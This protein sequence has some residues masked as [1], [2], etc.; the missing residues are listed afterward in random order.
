VGLG[1][2][3]PSKTLPA[4]TTCGT[5]RRSEVTSQLK[6][7]ATRDHCSAPGSAA[8]ELFRDGAAGRAV[9]CIMMRRLSPSTLPGRLGDSDPK[10]RI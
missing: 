9:G 1:L 4:H 7:V 10:L 3:E 6:T 2:A 8:E 5:D